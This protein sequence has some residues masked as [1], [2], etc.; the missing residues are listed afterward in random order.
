MLKTL[1]LTGVQQSRLQQA[2]LGL[3]SPVS[4]VTTFHAGSYWICFSNGCILYQPAC[5]S[6][7]HHLAHCVP[8]PHSSNACRIAQVHQIVEEAE[9]VREGWNGYNVF[10]DSAS[11]V[12]A[13]DVGFL[14]STRS[15]SAPPAKFVYL[16]GSD[17]YKEEDIPQDAFVVYQVGRASMQGTRGCS[18]SCDAMHCQ[19]RS[20]LY[21]ARDVC[22]WHLLLDA[23]S[24]VHYFVLDAVVSLLGHH[25]SARA[26][27][28]CQDVCTAS[29][30][31]YVR[32]LPT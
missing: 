27:C 15:A 28:A 3:R 17:D 18:T 16:L 14:P 24:L 26:Y 31:W 23:V 22:C 4:H 25:S 29:S 2:Y 7:S 5:M 19:Q 21:H 12:A 30:A 13:L 8:A 1:G 9:V 6:A 20:F 11:R 32:A 10:H